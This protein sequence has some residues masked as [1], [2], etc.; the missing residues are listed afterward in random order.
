MSLKS[1]CALKHLKILRPGRSCLELLL[2]VIVKNG[3]A[4][5]CCR[6]LGLYT[7]Q[8]KILAVTHDCHASIFV[9][10]LFPVLGVVQVGAQSMADRYFYIPGIAPFFVV[11]ICTATGYN[12]IVFLTQKPRTAI[13]V[14]DPEYAKAH[15][16]L[17]LAYESQGLLNKA[18]EAYT[19]A[20]SLNPDF[21]E[22]R[23][24]LDRVN[25]N[26]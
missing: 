9:V 14:L 10:T 12:K 11:G 1:F 21:N 23:D 4:T 7:N 22:A 24:Y 6:L 19:R 25:G 15:Y 26:R 17:G 3:Q 16:N 13:S 20:L 2:V 8:K 5:Y 18:V